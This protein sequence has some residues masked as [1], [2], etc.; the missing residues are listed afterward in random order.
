MYSLLILA[1][2]PCRAFQRLSGSTEAR[3]HQTKC[4]PSSNSNNERNT[5]NSI[6]TSNGNSDSNGNSK[7]ESKSNRISNNKTVIIIVIV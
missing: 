1:A 6:S 2:E 7:N 4:V 3:K 5:S